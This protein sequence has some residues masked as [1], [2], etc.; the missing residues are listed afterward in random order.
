MKLITAILVF[1][2]GVMISLGGPQAVTFEET[3]E[4]QDLKALW[5]LITADHSALVDLGDGARG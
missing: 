3:T 5:S 2:L 1:S 4:W